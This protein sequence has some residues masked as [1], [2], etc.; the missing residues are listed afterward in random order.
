MGKER[1]CDGMCRKRSPEAGT[2]ESCAARAVPWELW[3]RC[4][5][6]GQR[7]AGQAKGVSEQ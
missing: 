4:R 6:K 5:R 3:A 2:C 1:E 7:R